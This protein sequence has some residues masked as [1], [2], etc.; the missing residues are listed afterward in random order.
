[1]QN[2]GKNEEWK[3]IPNCDGMYLVSNTGKV[4]SNKSEKIIAQHKDKRGYPRVSLEICKHTKT[5]RVH[6]LVAEVFIPNP[7][8]LREV[9]HIDGDKTNNHVSN[10]EWV[11]TQQN[12][13]HSF[14]IGLRSRARAI[15]VVETGERFVT[16]KEFKDA[17]KVKSASQTTRALRDGIAVKGVHIRYDE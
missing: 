2:R 14:K 13:I 9:N 10:L 7:D 3:A 5:F 16:I 6:R 11:T 17:Y 15:F 1:M 12:M 4:W 8:N